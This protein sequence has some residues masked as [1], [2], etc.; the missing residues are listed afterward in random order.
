MIEDSST[1]TPATSS[2]TSL[3]STNVNPSSPDEPDYVHHLDCSGVEVVDGRQ[4]PSFTGRA[5]PQRRPT[6]MRTRRLTA[7]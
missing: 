4:I 5:F 7:T 1:E 2:Y 3:A 6:P